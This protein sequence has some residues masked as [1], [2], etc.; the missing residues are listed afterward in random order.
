[1][2]GSLLGGILGKYIAAGVGILGLSGL[3]YIGWLTI[4]L[5]T[6]ENI[7]LRQQQ[8]ILVQDGEI[9]G[10][11]LKEALQEKANEVLNKR[12]VQSES[13]QEHLNKQLEF[14]FSR[15]KEADGP[16]APVLE[17]VVRNPEELKHANQ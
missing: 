10:F 15:G 13:E 16:V 8:V 7:I 9:Q 3:L 4:Q 17:D 14:I 1:M 2:L 6:N 5:K 11:Q 12:L